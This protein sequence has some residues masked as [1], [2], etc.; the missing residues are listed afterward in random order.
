ML[1]FFKGTVTTTDWAIVGGIVTLTVLLC[2]GFY[3][4]IYTKQLEE[5]AR[6]ETEN[7]Q[8]MEELNAALVTAK[9]IDDLR[10]KASKMR[11]LV[12]KFETRLPEQR[13]INTLLTQFEK[14]ARDVGL[15]VELGM[16]PRIKSDQRKETIPYSVSTKGSFDDIVTFINRLERYQRYLKVSDLKIGPQQDRISTA[17][18]I[19]ST[20]RFKQS[21]PAAEGGTS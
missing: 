19:L 12:K 13:E 4:M 6:I 1:D 10:E 2:V 11:T 21:Q 5:V 20:Y 18:F 8:V 17:T 14:E 7:A 15:R 9:N 3:F 16:L